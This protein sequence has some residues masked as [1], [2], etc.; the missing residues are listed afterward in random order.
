MS[1]EI[2][3]TT[4]ILGVAMAAMGSA[5]FDYSPYDE[6]VTKNAF[7]NGP[8]MAWLIVGGCGCIFAFVAAALGKIIIR[9]RLADE[10]FTGSGP[11]GFTGRGNSD[12]PDAT[13]AKLHRGHLFDR[14]RT[15]WDIRRQ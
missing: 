13:T 12:S 15:D 8:M 9:K 4:L 10:H 7:L 5:V 3:K 1:Y 2:L 11:A 14:N 6:V